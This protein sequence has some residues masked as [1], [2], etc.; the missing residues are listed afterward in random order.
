MSLTSSPLWSIF[1]LL[2]RIACNYSYSDLINDCLIYESKSVT[3]FQYKV[4]PHRWSFTSNPS[5]ISLIREK[6]SYL[7]IRY[8]S[9]SKCQSLFRLL[10]S[11]CY[12]I[13]LAFSWNVRV[14]VFSGNVFICVYSIN[15]KAL[16]LG[17]I[18]LSTFDGNIV[19]WYFKMFSALWKRSNVWNTD[20]LKKQRHFI[21]LFFLLPFSSHMLRID[22][23]CL[24]FSCIHSCNLYNCWFEYFSFGLT[25]GYFQYQPI[26]VY[27]PLI[28]IIVN[29]NIFPLISPRDIFSIN[30]LTIEVHEMAYGFC[31][32]CEK[33]V[34]HR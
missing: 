30:G 16:I 6:R 1:K 15:F 28:C 33:N 24:N 2:F 32:P 34:S 13:Y 11:F 22:F 5:V 3:I 20:F 9:I 27:S 4:F 19:D 26:V 23:P 29:L 12:S 21:M 7:A 17:F 10:Y 14:E 25:K 31:G 8:M 18:L